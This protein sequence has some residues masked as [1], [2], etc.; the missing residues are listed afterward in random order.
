MRREFSQAV[1]KAAWKRAG[2]ICECG[3]GRP[4]DLNHPKGCPHYD[5]ELPDFLGGEP[6][7]ENCKVIRVD[8]HNAKTAADMERIKKVRRED[9][10]RTGTERP[11]KKIPYR[12]FDGTAVWKG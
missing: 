4:F 5:H 7:L 1:R 3:C 12:K 6:D 10:R 11:K 9:K 2:G 8:C